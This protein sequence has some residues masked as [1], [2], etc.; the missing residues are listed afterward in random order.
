MPKKNIPLRLHFPRFDKAGTD[1]AMPIVTSAPGARGFWGEGYPFDGM[2]SH[3]GKDWAGASLACKTITAGEHAGNMPL[4]ANS[5][6]KELLPRSVWIDFLHQTVVN[7]VGLSNLG[8][9]FYF[10]A[11]H[12]ATWQEPFY[13][14]LGF[15]GETSAARIEEARRFATMGQYYI[16]T[17]AARVALHVNFGCPNTSWLSTL[18]EIAIT[19]WVDEIYT[20]LTILEI[21]RIP[22]IP[23]F[24]SLID[25]EVLRLVSSHPGCAAF[26]IGNTVPWN[27]PRAKSLTKGRTSP[28]IQRGLKQPGGISSPVFFP[29]TLDVVEAIRNADITQPIITGGGIANIHD[30]IRLLDAGANAIFLG[31]IGITRPWRVGPII[32]DV[33]Q[34]RNQRG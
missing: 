32:Q 10:E 31:S 27:H 30:A 16:P 34:Y 29:L 11:G 22:I 5:R 23:S 28:L 14:S 12:W 17:F 7:A 1:T 25:L 3:I 6:P 13:L 2:L 8:A 15:V 9:R 4:D 33:L 26:W 19:T 18:D 24:S 21:L 20:I